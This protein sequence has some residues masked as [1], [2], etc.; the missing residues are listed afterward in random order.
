MIALALSWNQFGAMV[1]REHLNDENVSL[2]NKA[3]FI[4]IIGEQDL[5]RMPHWFQKDHPN[6]LRLLFDDVDEPLQV[7]LLGRDKREYI[8]VVP[9]S[10]EQGKAILAFIEQNSHA[11]VCVVHCAAG[12]KR[13][14]AVAQFINDWADIDYF[15][16]RSLNPSTKPNARILSILRNVYR[17]KYK[18]EADGYT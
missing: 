16:A 4:E 11:D 7:P 17:D 1:A 8:S 12:V 3:C 13:S 5:L 14:G 9:M 15:T 6:V 10:E 18:E 2:K